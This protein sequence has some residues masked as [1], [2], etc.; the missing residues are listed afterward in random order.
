M[1]GSRPLV[2]LVLLAF[3]MPC[4]AQRPM[5]VRVLDS[6]SGA[7]LPYASVVSAGRAHGGALI[8]NEEGVFR[9]PPA[10]AA[11]TVAVSYLGYRTAR[12]P[13]A[14]LAA[15]PVVRL[16]PLATELRAVEVRG[17]SDAL[18]NL[19]VRA[20]KNVRRIAPYEARTYFELRSRSEGLPM[21]AIECFYNGH[22]A[23]GNIEGLDLKQGRIGLLPHQG[24][25]VSN[26]NTSRAFMLLHPAERNSA[27]PASPL[28][29]TSAAKLRG[30]YGLQLV[31]VARGPQVLY[32]IAFT[33]KD[34]SG[35]FFGGEVWVDSASAEVQRLLLQCRDCRKHPFQPVWPGAVLHRLDLDHSLT[36]ARWN[37]RQILATA[38]MDYSVTFRNTG[39][40][41]SL[42]AA[43]PAGYKRDRTM[44]SKGILHAYAPGSRFLLPYFDYDKD[45]TDYWKILAMPYDSMFWDAAPTLVR[46]PGQQQDQ[47]LFAAQG[48]LAGYGLP[49][50]PGR[51][52]P[53]F[54]SS[55]AVWSAHRRIRIKDLQPGTGA[56]PPQ[57]APGIGGAQPFR[58]V[59]QLYLNVD[60]GAHALRI[61]SAT[62]FDGF[63]SRFEGTGPQDDLALNI[64][65]DLCEIERRK[66]Q[67]ALERPGITLEQVT[68]A[69]DKAELNM[70][71]T[72]FR[73]L[74][75]LRSP[76][77]QEKLAAWNQLVRTELG[78][79]NCRLFGITTGK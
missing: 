6:A 33:P 38:E 2:S 73:F 55:Y 20:G 10:M 31:S 18:Y 56:R 60:S 36:F 28:Q 48:L 69:H 30:H 42:A 75:D 51:E 59:V 47:A 70:K 25:Y 1:A 34:S 54:G 78:V 62:V 57:P 45:Q 12:F 65:F 40:G 72:G 5:D 76:Q 50:L 3:A 52:L 61:F 71:R 63:R 17:R 29:Y 58:P 67:A 21:E 9:L 11:D 4:M 22:F 27:F 19:L 77:A 26:L 13:A 16:E 44:Q 53:L 43:R 39:A 66:M 35:A 32:R 14:A 7:P 49:G 79:D 46:T 37:G 41:D 23:G 24:R 15:L 74:D 8:A 64:Y 68:L